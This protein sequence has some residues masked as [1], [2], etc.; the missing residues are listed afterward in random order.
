MKSDSRFRAVS[1]FIGTSP[2]I[3]WVLL[4]GLTLISTLV[5]SPYKNDV[6]AIYHQGDVAEGDIK[7]P[8]DFFIEDREATLQNQL[9]TVRTI[10]FVYDY[11]PGL[12]QRI[13]QRIDQ[14]F[15]IPRELFNQENLEAPPSLAMVMASREK[16][17]ENLGIPMSK[18]AYTI[19]HKN[20][21][22][23]DV[24]QLIKTILKQILDNGVV[25]NKELLLKEED[26]GILLKTIDS[27]Q[28]R[29]VTTL[30]TFYGPDQAKAMVRIIGDPL[31]KGISYGM[32]NLIVDMCQRLMLPNITMNRNETEQ[33]IKEAE[34]NVKPVL[35][36]IKKGE[37]I[38]REGERVDA[39]KMVKLKALEQQTHGKNIV[40]ARIGSG[41]LIF[42]SILTIY[43]TSLRDHK[44]LQKHHNR[45]IIFITTLLLIFMVIAKLGIPIAG[46]MDLALALPVTIEG[47]SIFM[48]LPLGAGAMT[49]CMFLGFHVALYF[50]LLLS[51]LVS[52]I[53]SSRMDVFLFFFLS[54]M[55]GAF[56]IKD[57][58]ERKTFI[59]AGFKLAFFNGVLAFFMYLYAATTP[60]ITPIL[61]DVILAACG[62]FIAGVITAGLT[63]VMEMVFGFTT[64]ITLLELSNL[65]QPL[66]KRLM[67][68]APG[69]YNHSIIVSS[70]AEAAASAIG[71]SILKAKIC[72]YYHDI[73][74]LDKPLYFI[75]NQT[76]GKNR[77]DKLSPSMSALVLIQ[78]VKKG[79]AFAKEYK[80]GSDIV[81]TIRQHH[82]TSLIRYFYNKSVKLHGKDA[83]KTSDFRY[84]GPKPQTRE[85]GI[86]MLADVV[87]AALRTLERPT[88]ARIQ[89]RVQDLIN[90]IFADGQLEECELTLKDLHQIAGSFNKILT[91]LYHH[92][93]E[94]TDKPQ[95]TKKETNG[96][97]EY[98]NSDSGKSDKDIKGQHKPKSQQ[99]LKRLGI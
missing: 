5:L 2:S 81:N 49:V 80:L 97:K 77:H 73:G 64:E 84:P 56:W 79:V 78:H 39:L 48:L 52:I 23:Q 71:A 91:G 53:I 69:T 95:E 72:A 88:S 24:P 28:E 43:I 33:R 47:A 9:V 82:G 63:P 46:K 30:K 14:S 89:G 41:L 34:A 54:S 62:G 83:V 87:E 1:I 7:A 11:D 8:R 36:Q 37:M 93:I 70:L 57:C 90:A 65:D 60:Q 29:L 16:F 38:L 3:L 96:K 61:K 40:T 18:G 50:S 4:I 98:T 42:L 21:F 20:K 22:S 31:L 51:L 19:L 32:S 55:T 25:A 59:S 26:K 44:N 74:K 92:R 66:M 15:T 99:N 67:M 10:P 6:T 94:Y 68:E 27:S 75:E 17:E 13:E 76:D 86:V 85:A 58:R 12:F 35:Y 45:N